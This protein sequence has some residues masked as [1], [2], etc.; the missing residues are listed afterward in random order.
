[1]V[2]FPG[3]TYLPTVYTYTDA[4][5]RV[6]TMSST[7]QLQTIKDLNGNILTFAANG[8]T[9]SAGNV[10]VPFV[11][12]SQGRITTITD[13]NHNNYVYSYDSPCG[14]GNLVLG[15]ISRRQHTSDLPYDTTPSDVS[16][17]ALLTET[18]PNGN[19]WINTVL[20]DHC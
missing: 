18:D 3:G 12:D 20:S 17:N 13:L 19:T 16:F 10:V 8:I 2:C 15:N 1:M 5:G 4:A 7:G 9:S 6:Y 11:R 14:T